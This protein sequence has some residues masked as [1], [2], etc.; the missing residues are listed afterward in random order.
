MPSEIAVTSNHEP[1]KGLPPVAPPSGK[2]IAQL[3]LVP[4]LIVGVV[5]LLVS[6]FFWL[7]GDRTDPSKLLSQ[8]DSPNA[9]VRWRA[10]S[11]FAQKLKRDPNLASS[12]KVALQL[13]TLLRQALDEF[14]RVEKD[15]AAP[16][17]SKARQTFLEKRKNIQF[18]SPCLGNLIIPTGAPLL[19]EIAMRT[20]DSDPKTAALLRR[21]AVWALANLGDNLKQ[22]PKLSP[23][24]VDEV[25]LELEQEAAAGPAEQAAWARQTLEYLNG[26][27]RQ[28]RAIPILAECARADDPVLRELAAYALTFWDGDAEDNALAEKTLLALSY[29]DGHGVRVEVGEN[30]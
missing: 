20:S 12:P 19:G 25:K 8:L 24:H 21:Q 23:E 1:E 28:I 16:A 10:A 5:V 7:M 6:F 14:G 22:F 30:D 11:E 18:L 17:D 29:D 2:F 3:F 9:D 15:A 13:S 26:D 27:R 4:L